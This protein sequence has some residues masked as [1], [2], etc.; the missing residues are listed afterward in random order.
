[1]PSTDVGS[2][3]VNL[4]SLVIGLHVVDPVEEILASFEVKIGR[5]DR[6][7]PVPWQLSDGFH[8]RSQ[9]IG[10]ETDLVIERQFC[11]FNLARYAD[12]HTTGPRLVFL[13]SVQKGV[14]LKRGLVGFHVLPDQRTLRIDRPLGVRL[15]PLNRDVENLRADSVTRGDGKDYSGSLRDCNGLL[16]PSS[17]QFRI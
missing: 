17:G 7:L 5:V 4:S 3:L 6:Y 16:I 10:V 2:S 1:M 12:L 15:V 8:C 11:P 14:G 13:Q 9:L